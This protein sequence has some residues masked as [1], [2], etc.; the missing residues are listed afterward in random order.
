MIEHDFPEDFVPIAAE[1]QRLPYLSP[2]RDFADRV[3]SGVEKLRAPALASSVGSRHL[4][5]QRGGQRAVAPRPR[6]A[7][8]RATG[9][10]V[11]GVGLVVVAAFMF[12]EI[13]VLTAILSAAAT[14]YGFVIAAAGGQVAAMILGPSTV[15]Y[16]QSGALDAVLL[17]LMLAVGLFG[18][19]AAIRTAAHIAHRK[20]A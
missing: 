2:S 7:V 13:D 15:A 11:V 10:A 19:Y 14:Q 20:A 3:I 5:L 17:Y 18:G 4:E 12:F 9:K 6:M 8:A 1:L 16:L